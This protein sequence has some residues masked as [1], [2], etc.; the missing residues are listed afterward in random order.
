M[1]LQWL[2]NTVGIP[3]Y[4]S[5]IKTDS[6]RWLSLRLCSPEQPKQLESGGGGGGGAGAEVV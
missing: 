4:M 6:H 3:G 1:Q 5:Q 2:V